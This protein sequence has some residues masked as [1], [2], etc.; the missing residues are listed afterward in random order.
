VCLVLF[1]TRIE[2]SPTVRDYFIRHSIYET[3]YFAQLAALPSGFIVHFIKTKSY[4]RDVSVHSMTHPMPGGI[5]MTATTTT[6]TTMETPRAKCGEE[7]N[8]E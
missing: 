5:M 6:D 1:I 3:C 2:G 7:D 8:T 4:R